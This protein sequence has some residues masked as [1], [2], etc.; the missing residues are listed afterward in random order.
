MTPGES[1]K[2]REEAGRAGG[3]QGALGNAD[4]VGG[5][6][7]GGGSATPLPQRKA[8]IMLEIQAKQKEIDDALDADQFGKAKQLKKERMALEEALLR[9]SNSPALF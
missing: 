6:D 9:L 3:R 5:G 1:R 7:G 8:N 4:G 2:E